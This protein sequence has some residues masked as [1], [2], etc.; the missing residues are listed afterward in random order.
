M[1]I[2]R[3]DDFGYNS[4]IA[5]DL[6][7]MLNE[8]PNTVEGMVKDLAKRTGLE[9]YIKIVNAQ[10]EE[11][12]INSLLDI[13]EVKEAVDKAIQGKFYSNTVNLLKKLEE[14]IKHNTKIPEYLKNVFSD[15][16]LKDYV[17]KFIQSQEEHNKIDLTV[18]KDVEETSDMH[19]PY[20]N[21]TQDQNANK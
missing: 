12:K 16:K 11:P 4:S 17:E 19:S 15:N 9:D 6:N 2:Y 7:R 3:S 10:L 8:K 5:Y 14:Q 20:F 1:P 13:A 18:K 21:F